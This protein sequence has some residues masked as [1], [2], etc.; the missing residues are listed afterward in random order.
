MT[1]AERDELIRSLY[2]NSNSLAL[3]VQVLELAGATEPAR[4]AREAGR[5][6]FLAI[7][8]LVKERTV[9]GQS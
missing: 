4:L 9:E 6:V 5:A 1:I 3:S 2:S 8:E 7:V